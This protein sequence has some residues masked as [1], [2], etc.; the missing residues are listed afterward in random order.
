MICPSSTARG[1]PALALPPG[2]L[3]LHTQPHSPEVRC[4][5]WLL[6]SPSPDREGALWL[7]LTEVERMSNGSDYDSTHTSIPVLIVLPVSLGE[8]AVLSS[9]C[10]FKECEFEVPELARIS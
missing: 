10:Q 7:T 3:Q 9:G 5:V 6:K 2:S 8:G 1:P 4:Q